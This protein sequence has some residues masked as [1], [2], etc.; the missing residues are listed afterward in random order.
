ARFLT[1]VPAAATLVG[2]LGAVDG[3]VRP[4]E[5]G[6]RRQASVEKTALAGGVQ[7]RLA[8]QS[9]ILVAGRLFRKLS[10]RPQRRAGIFLLPERDRDRDHAGVRLPGTGHSVRA[11]GLLGGDALRPDTP[12]QSRLRLPGVGPQQS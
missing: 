5:T 12:I 11:Q 1:T 6:A 7:G 4:A 9:A 8:S 2:H 10:A 3:G